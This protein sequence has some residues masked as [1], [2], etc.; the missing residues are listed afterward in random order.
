MVPRGRSKVARNKDIFH[1]SCCLWWN[2][3]ITWALLMLSHCH[4]RR[5]LIQRSTSRLPHLLRL[6]FKFSWHTTWFYL[7]LYA[8]ADVR[9]ITCSI[10]IQVN[11]SFINAQSNIQHMKY[12]EKTD[13]YRLGWLPQIRWVFSEKT[14]LMI[15]SNTPR[16]LMINA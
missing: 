1:E 12:G 10:L 16:K 8:P 3:E 9:S 15:T 14:E 4:M 11:C 13:D 2:G 6:D 5:P 7:V